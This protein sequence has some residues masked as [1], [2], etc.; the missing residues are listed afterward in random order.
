LHSKKK[1]MY[2]LLA[3][4]FFGFVAAQQPQPC[5][6]PQQW[7]ANYFDIND[8][9]RFMVRGRIAYDAVY[10]RE[11]VIEEV[12]VGPQGSFYEVLALFDTQTEYIFDL[13]ARNCTRR[14]LTRPW[15]DFG[16]AGNATSRGEGYIGTS[17]LPGAGLLVSIW[18]V[19][20]F[21]IVTQ[22]LYLFYQ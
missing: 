15:R 2:A 22:C 7:E 3:I 11:H 18:Y 4:C 6:T 13:R 5:I 1:E 8:Q 10:H 16:I 9:T 20:L 14:P 21:L 19:I 12:D 17:A